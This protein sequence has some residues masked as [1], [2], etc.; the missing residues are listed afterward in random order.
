MTLRLRL[1][2]L[3]GISML[4]AMVGILACYAPAR[5]AMAIDP[6]QAVRAE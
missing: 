2:L 1:L 6:T 3:I 4:L 5:R